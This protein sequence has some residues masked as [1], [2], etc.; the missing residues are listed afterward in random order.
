LKKKRPA[1]SDKHNAASI[2]QQIQCSQHHA[3][4]ITQPASCSKYN[5]A[6]IMQQ[7]QRNQH[8]AAE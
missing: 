6:S 2:M 4:S 8:D 1:S 3:T 5:A 7:A